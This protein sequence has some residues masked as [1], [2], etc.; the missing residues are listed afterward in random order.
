MKSLRVFLESVLD[1]GKYKEDQY[2]SRRHTAQQ[3]SLLYLMEHN[4]HQIEELPL[5]LYRIE[6][7]HFQYNMQVEMFL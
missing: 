7:S 4:T 2:E 5:L 1:R 6:S 3:I